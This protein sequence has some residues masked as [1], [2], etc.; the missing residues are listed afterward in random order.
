MII[1]EWIISLFAFIV[2]LVFFVQT[3]TFPHVNADPGGLALFPRVFSIFTGLSALFLMISLSKHTAENP[4]RYVSLN[5]LR[6]LCKKFTSGITPLLMRNTFYSIILCLIFPALIVMIGFLSSTIIFVFVLM[7]IL[8][9]KLLNSTLYSV[10][11][12]GSLYYI[13]AVIIGVYLP[14]GRFWEYILN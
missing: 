9:S 6:T 10:L 4:H 14:A 3:F 11:L 7:K 12:G 8:G 2:S 13:F 1:G 5:N